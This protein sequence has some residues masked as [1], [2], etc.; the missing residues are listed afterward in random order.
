ME[1]AYWLMHA[2]SAVCASR[3]LVHH[4]SSSTVKQSIARPSPSKMTPVK[5]GSGYIE[6]PCRFANP[7]V[8]ETDAGGTSESSLNSLADCD[9]LTRDSQVSNYIGATDMVM[10]RWNF[11]WADVL[12]FDPSIADSDS[13]SSLGE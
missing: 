6:E 3:L 13:E 8:T 10:R 1:S 9:T 4:Q 2:L 7:T 11:P 12:V 5:V